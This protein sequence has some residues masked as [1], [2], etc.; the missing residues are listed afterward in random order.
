[1]Y[2]KRWM[3]FCPNDVIFMMSVNRTPVWLNNNA[4]V[5]H[6]FLQFPHYQSAFF[7]IR[8]CKRF[9]QEAIELRV[10][11]RAFVPASRSIA[12]A[13]SVVFL[14]Q[15]SSIIRFAIVCCIFCIREM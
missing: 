9:S 2:F 15:V 8:D 14:R 10:R 4:F 1:M 13:A 5:L 11:K 6:D 3:H 7:R 12:E